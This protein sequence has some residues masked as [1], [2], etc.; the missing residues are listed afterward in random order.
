MFQQIQS[1]VLA[2]VPE[3][4][5]QPFDPVLL[6]QTERPVALGEQIDFS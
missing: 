4:A 2:M 6:D 3:A 1:V 5:M